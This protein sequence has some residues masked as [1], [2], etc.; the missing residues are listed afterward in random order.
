MRSVKA[1]KL[2]KYVYKDEDYRDRKY[3]KAP[4]GQITCD[5]KRHIYK[6]LK[7]LATYAYSK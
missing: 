2:R 1:K 3:R 7:K 4:N 5:E 6:N